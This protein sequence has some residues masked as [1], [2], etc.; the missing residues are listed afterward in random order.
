[1]LT[2]SD[3]LDGGDLQRTLEKHK[4]RKRWLLEAE[5]WLR[6]PRDVEMLTTYDI[7]YG[8]GPSFK[9]DVPRSVWEP[10]LRAQVD[11]AKRQVSELDRIVRDYVEAALKV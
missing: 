10:Q 3:H 1:M 8:D 6:S 11:E 5:S 9:F 7:R 2:S 4:Y